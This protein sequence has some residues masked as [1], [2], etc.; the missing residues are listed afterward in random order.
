VKESRYA[1]TYFKKEIW[2]DVERRYNEIYDV[3]SI[4]WHP[5]IWL[6]FSV[7]I[8][9]GFDFVFM[10]VSIGYMVDYQTK[11]QDINYFLLDQGHHTTLSLPRMMKVLH[12]LKEGESIGKTD[13]DLYAE[14]IDEVEKFYYLINPDLN[15]NID[16]THDMLY[17]GDELLKSRATLVEEGYITTEDDGYKYLEDM[18]NVEKSIGSQ[19]PL[20]FAD[21]EELSHHGATKIVIWVEDFTHEFTWY[22]QL[23]AELSEKGKLKEWIP[24]YNA[25]F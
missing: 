25:A 3:V 24:K 8:P 22:E 14:S 21:A 4:W 11:V 17:Y 2:S 7:Y 15:D 5:A 13:I 6:I 1:S 10:F 9:L 23:I 12:F 16:N 19:V 18:I 20:L